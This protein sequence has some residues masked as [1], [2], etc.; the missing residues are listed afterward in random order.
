MRAENFRF[1]RCHLHSTRD[2]LQR[3]RAA[4]CAH[5]T[6][7]CSE[8]FFLEEN[9]KHRV[10]ILS[11][12]RRIQGAHKNNG[13]RPCSICQPGLQRSIPSNPNSNRSHWWV[14]VHQSRLSKIQFICTNPLQPRLSDH[15]NRTAPMCLPLDPN[16]NENKF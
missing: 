16:S 1:L 4:K 7:T 12:K 6:Q 8:R 2:V 9:V 11:S 14:A 5:T 10:L 3:S 15:S 13:Q